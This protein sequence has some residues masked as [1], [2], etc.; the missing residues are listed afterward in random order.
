MT[1]NPPAALSKAHIVQQFWWT[2]RQNGVSK[3]FSPFSFLTVRSVI[4]CIHN[5]SQSSP[6]RYG[7]ACHYSLT[8]SSSCWLAGMP[9]DMRQAD[10]GTYILAGASWTE[11]CQLFFQR[12]FS[13]TCLIRSKTVSK[14]DRRRKKEKKRR[15]AIFS[16]LS[17]IWLGSCS[18][19]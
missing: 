13:L 14:S 16:F 19:I 8:V 18:C 10:I 4:V 15:R 11:G 6:W 9:E 7:Q 2:G 1:R 3:V 12:C 17:Q 5:I